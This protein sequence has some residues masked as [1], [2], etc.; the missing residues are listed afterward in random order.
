MNWLKSK[1]DITKATNVL[2]KFLQ[3]LTEG[4]SD[5]DDDLEIKKLLPDLY[6]KFK[7]T[8]CFKQK[9]RNPI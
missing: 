4:A 9:A 8:V 2:K 6:I 7:G 1:Q 3:Y 5:Y